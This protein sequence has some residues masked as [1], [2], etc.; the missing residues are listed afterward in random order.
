MLGD[1]FLKFSYSTYLYCT[2]PQANEGHLTAL[3]SYQ[4]ANLNLYEIGRFNGI[5]EC[6]VAQQM[7]VTQTANTWMPP[8]YKCKAEE[9]DGWNMN[10]FEPDDQGDWNG[11]GG[12][13]GS[14]NEEN[15]GETDKTNGPTD[16]EFDMSDLQQIDKSFTKVKIDK[17]GKASCMS[18]FKF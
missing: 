12:A 11:G 18:H 5:A 8:L 4:V 16:M 14:G 13:V 15:D 17:H 2:Y 3:R 1:S 6:I 10:Q 7:E 9:D